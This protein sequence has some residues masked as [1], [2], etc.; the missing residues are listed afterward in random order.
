M[1]KEYYVLFMAM[2]Y[3][4]SCA[5]QRFT[6][7]DLN[8]FKAN[9][10]LDEIQF[11]ISDRLIL[12]PVERTSRFDINGIE[13]DPNYRLKYPKGWAGVY[14]TLAEKGLYRVYDEI[15]DVWRLKN[16]PHLEKDSIF[17]Q[18]GAPLALQ[19]FGMLVSEDLIT[20]HVSGTWTRVFNYQIYD[21]SGHLYLIRNP[22]PILLGAVLPTGT[23][24]TY[25]PEYI[26]YQSLS[27]P[28]IFLVKHRDTVHK[29]NPNSLKYPLLYRESSNAI[30]IEYGDDYGLWFEPNAITGNYELSTLNGSSSQ[31]G[32]YV[33]INGVLY[34]KKKLG[35]VYLNYKQKRAVVQ[36]VFPKSARI[37]RQQR[38][39]NNRR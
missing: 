34:E 38:I 17:I 23:R 5:P 1:R 33:Q 14:G 35:F 4:T 26:I 37:P 6:L 22:N 30:Y 20:Q 8:H 28:T 7:N 3:L 39:A 21:Q 19:G 10:D 16:K 13:K 29:P 32:L 9:H 25:V 11:F 31:G 36:E 18:K 2:L 15:N 27:D 24:A 12:D